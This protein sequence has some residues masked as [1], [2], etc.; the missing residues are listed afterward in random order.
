[1]AP[2]AAS[3][4]TASG[5]R[6]ARSSTGRAGAGAR[7]RRHAVTRRRASACPGDAG[8]AGIRRDARGRAGG[9]HHTAGRRGA[10][11]RRA[12]D[13]GGPA[14]DR[15]LRVRCRR[16]ARPAHNPY[17]DNGIKFFG[18]DG[19]KLSDATEAAIERRLDEAPTA[20]RRRD[21]TRPGAARHA[22]GLPRKAP[23]FV[24]SGRLP[25]PC[26]QKPVPEASRRVGTGRTFPSRIEISRP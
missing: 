8:H 23:A 2:Q 25:P 12:A 4:P 24:G 1:M 26:A 7:S 3:A 13:P 21:R 6:R 5:A 9:G 16:R 10:A 22:G 15:P 17:R 18:A 20:A 19:F 14:A 11:R